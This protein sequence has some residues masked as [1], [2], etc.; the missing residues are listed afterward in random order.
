MK[1]Y[2]QKSFI[3]KKGVRETNQ[4]SSVLPIVVCRNT[5]RRS[6]NNFSQYNII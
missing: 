5:F 2:A 4:N 1:P 3:I 6:D